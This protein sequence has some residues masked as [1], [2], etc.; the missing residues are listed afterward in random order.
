MTCAIIKSITYKQPQRNVTPH[1]P[2]LLITLLLV[3]LL[4]YLI[5]FYNVDD[6]NDGGYDA[7]YRVFVLYIYIYII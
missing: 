1:Q 4:R 2:T 3:V 5:T 7:C 6:N